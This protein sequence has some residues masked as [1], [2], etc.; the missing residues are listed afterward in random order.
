MSVIPRVIAHLL[1]SATS[2]FA[3]Q[4]APTDSKPRTAPSV[5]L[6]TAPFPD[7]VVDEAAYRQ[8][9]ADRSAEAIA[10][11]DAAGEDPMGVIEKRLA[12]VSAILASQCEPPMSR[13][14]LGLS[15]AADRTRVLELTDRAVAL[16]KT[17]RADLE[18]YENA[19]DFA[20]A[21][22]DYFG[23]TIELFEVFAGALRNCVQDDVGDQATKRYR[24]AARD[25][26]VYLED[27]RHQVAAAA[28]LWQG[29]L[30]GKADRVD[31]ALRTLPLPDEPIRRG[32]LRYDFFARLLRCRYLVMR[33]AYAA[34]WS[35]LLALEER[36]HDSFPTAP[37]RRE[38]AR[39]TILLK[40][41]ICDAWA[42]AG[43]ETAAAT[44]A[45]CAETLGRIREE[46]LPPGESWTV[47]RLDAAAPRIIAPPDLH[48]EEKPPHDDAENSGEHQ[49]A[50]PPTPQP[51]GDID[52]QPK[53][54]DTPEP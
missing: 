18:R 45:W 16:L 41:E 11:A 54:N 47:V 7:G 38:A 36:A 39:S 14:L 31:R 52:E 9:L 51:A 25:L 5:Q 26:S 2:A 10:A 49:N 48:P 6:S 15:D 28:M 27:D 4:T 13:W 34:A 23:S 3:G 21:A 20:E 12:A 17:A 35:L 32:A 22:A 29:A 50:Q 19:P 30:Y 46:Q 33:Q 37:E 24:D 1:V 8:W 44:R 43:D 42:S 53:A 40:T